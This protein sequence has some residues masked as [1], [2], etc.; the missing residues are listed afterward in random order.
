MADYRNHQKE[1][2]N[3]GGVRFTELQLCDTE[4]P[5]CIGCKRCIREGEESCPHHET[6]GKIAGYIEDADC[7]IIGSSVY[8]L[9]V[10]AITKN[11]LEHMAY[12]F[13]RPRYF[14]K[15]A[16]VVTASEKHGARETATY[17]RKIFKYWG[18]NRV[19]KLAVFDFDVNRFRKVKKTLKMITKITGR[20]Y[21]DV[22]SGRLYQ[23]TFRQL[24]DYNAARARSLFFER[25]RRYWFESG[26][27]N[28][29][30]SPKL[31]LG[32][33]EKTLGNL[34]FNVMSMSFKR[35]EK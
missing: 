14:T 12:Q 21:A 3:K 5:F 22:E 29:P 26:L 34:F 35:T 11:F 17:I 4:L 31:H 6:V 24:F 10:A 27:I 9:A 32:I 30:F 15:K 28:A 33:L 2:G 20:F 16:L 13:R 25:D 18:F 7:V 19:Y 23:P 1:L 8:S